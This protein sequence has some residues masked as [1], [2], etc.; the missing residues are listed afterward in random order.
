[1]T[2]GKLH[3]RHLSRDHSQKSALKSPSIGE[4]PICDGP[5]VPLAQYFGHIFGL[6]TNLVT[7]Y[8]RTRTGTDAQKPRRS[9]LPRCWCWV[10]I[11][12]GWC[13]PRRGGK[14]LARGVNILFGTELAAHF[15]GLQSANGYRSNHANQRKLKSRIIGFGR[16]PWKIFFK[17]VG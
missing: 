6:P 9:I 17:N 3:A 11:P 4:I 5:F 16:A 7:R 1:M 14:R 15:E 12:L 10:Q 2:W 8:S 13:W